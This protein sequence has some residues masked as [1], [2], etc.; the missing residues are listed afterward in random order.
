M[1]KNLFITHPAYQP[2][3]LRMDWLC[4]YNSRKYPL[5]PQ[6]GILNI[7]KEI[8][9]VKPIKR[10]AITSTALGVYRLFVNGE[11][12]GNPCDDSLVYDE[13]KPGWTD[14]KHCVLSYEYD[15]TPMMQ[16]SNV[17]LAEIGLGWWGGHINNG[18][19]GNQAC[20][21]AAEILL[22]YADGTAETIKTDETWDAMIG[23]PTRYADIWDGQYYDA[24]Y[25]HPAAAPEA[26]SWEKAI[27]FD[28]FEGVIAPNKS[29]PIRVRKH[30]CQEPKTAFVYEGTIDNGTDMGAVRVLHRALGDG[31]EKTKLTQG[32]SLVVDFGQEIVGWPSLTLSGKAGTEVEVFFAEF[33]NDS[34]M[35]SRGNDGPKGSPYLENYRAALSR[36]VVK[37]SGQANQTYSPYLTFYGF[38]YLEI[39]AAEDIEIHCVK[40]EVVGSDLTE[41]GTFTCDN[42]EVNR[43]Y[44]NVVWGMRGNY[45]SVPTDCPQRNE[46]LGW[47]GDTQLFSGAAAYLADIRNFMHQWL[48]D[49]RHSQ[50]GYDGAYGDIV[51]RLDIVKTSGNAAWGDAGII[52][53]YKLYLMY[54]DTDILKEHYDS[55]EWYMRY[56]EGNGLKGPASLY[57]DWLNYDVTDKEYVSVCYYAYDLSLMQFFSRLLSKPDREAYYKNKYEQVLTFWKQTYIKDGKLTVNTQTGYLLPMAFDMVPP[58]LLEDFKASLRSL[59][60]NNDYTLSTGFVGTAIL[61]QTLDKMGMS[62][63]CYSLLLQTKDPSWLYSVRQGATTIWERWN[64]YTLEHGFGDVTMNSFNHYAYGAV[65]EWLYAGMCGICPDEKHPGFERFILKPTPDLRTFI[66]DGQTRI[67]S[68]KATFRSLKGR[69]ESAWACV[70]GAYEYDFVIPAGTQAS[71]SLLAGDY[72]EFN[73]LKMTE[74][75]LHAVREDGRLIFTLNPGSYHI[76][77]GIK[78]E[79]VC[80]Q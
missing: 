10:A 9:A 17:V 31:C 16:V 41:T 27:L 77:T 24:A 40:G 20:A 32:Q 61:C 13:L 69:I 22:E 65:A 30:L 6:K 46:R 7:K 47:T 66:P 37:L 21:F 38:R 54:K 25:P 33:L 74:K 44:A 51:P 2:M 23:G 19:Y 18:T 78:T 57:G 5:A 48:A 43:L 50:I 35:K 72:L 4:F 28:G 63:L 11:R 45:L 52:V 29:E 15:I 42:P 79:G 12:V 55:M 3:E 75:D 49:C 60:E 64:S 53:P 76:R 56:L 68:A 70:N 39:R 73:G 58:E 62:D 67:N 36:Y 80:V 1:D 34:G 8:H 14:Y 26:Y 59:I 71:V